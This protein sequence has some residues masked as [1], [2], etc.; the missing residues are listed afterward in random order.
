MDEQQLATTASEQLDIKKI[1]E[2]FPMLKKT[3]GGKQLI[4]L[5]SAATGQ[6]PEVVMKRLYQYYTEEY[7]KPKEAHTLS[8]QTTKEMEDVRSKVASFIGAE[9]AEEIVFSRGCT[10]SINMVA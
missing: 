1:R 4:Y 2:D 9:R 10:E 6:K 7:G 8:Q 5:D 3:I